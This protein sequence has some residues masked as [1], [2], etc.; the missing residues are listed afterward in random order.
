MDM[1]KL[2][3]PTQEQVDQSIGNPPTRIDDGTAQGDPP[4]EEKLV[5][6]AS[7]QFDPNAGKG[8]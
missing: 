1:S 4:P 6:A 5:P 3:Q 8:G 7:A 2:P